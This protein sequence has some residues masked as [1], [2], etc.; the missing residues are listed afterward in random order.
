MTTSIHRYRRMTPDMRPQDPSLRGEGLTFETLEHGGEEPDAMPQAIKLI[1]AEGRWCIY[2][3]TTENGKVVQSRGYEHQE[4][5]R[6][7]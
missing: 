2:V 1:D 6:L 4:D 7:K 3:P 5:P